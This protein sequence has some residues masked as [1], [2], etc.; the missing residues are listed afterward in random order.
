METPDSKHELPKITEY[1]NKGF[2]SSYQM[3]DGKLKDLSTGKLFETSEVKIIETYRYEGM[4]DP[5]DMSILYALE[6]NDGKKGTLLMAYGPAADGEL[7]WF[8]KEVPTEDPE[9]NM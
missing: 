4:S 6:T 3:E 1:T 7:A 2:T 5:N 9:A 8:M